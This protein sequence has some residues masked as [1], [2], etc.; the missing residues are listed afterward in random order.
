MPMVDNTYLAYTRPNH[1]VGVIGDTTTLASSL[2]GSSSVRSSSTRASSFSTAR[3]NLRRWVRTRRATNSVHC[4]AKS[5]KTDAAAKTQKFDI[6][7]MRVYEP[8]RKAQASVADVVKI[9]GPASPIASTMRCDTT[10]S[11]ASSRS[12][13]SMMP[14]TSVANLSS[15][16]PPTMTKLSSRPIPSTRNAA[17]VP[18][19]LSSTPH[20]KHTPH[21][22]AIA[23]ATQPTANNP[24]T[25]RCLL[26][27]SR[28]LV[29][30]AKYA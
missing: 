22:A 5:A 9:D 14:S 7:G 1:D 17:I 10:A 25:P 12:F 20:A 24:N 13:R 27:C 21:A 28:R 4:R 15:S 26:G 6:A 16:I 30:V 2:V 11:S 29:V 3:R 8:A 19:G 18:S 23:S